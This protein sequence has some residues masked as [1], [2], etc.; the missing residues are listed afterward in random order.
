MMSRRELSKEKPLSQ[1]R[2]S[3]G[4]LRETSVMAID[5][6]ISALFQLWLSPREA[7]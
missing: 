4:V 3:G 7:F 5:P 6:W 1:G 2:D